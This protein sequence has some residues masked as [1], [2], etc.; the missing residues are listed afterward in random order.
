M[1]LLS[2]PDAVRLR[3]PGARR[4]HRPAGVFVPDGG[5]RFTPDRADALL[6]TRHERRAGV[7]V[8]APAGRP[9]SP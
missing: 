2:P 9:R 6:D 3:E 5:A 1:T 7:T 8:A 4:R